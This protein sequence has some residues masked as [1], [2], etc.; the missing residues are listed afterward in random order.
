M[1]CRGRYLCPFAGVER[2]EHFLI[3]KLQQLHPETCSDDKT[4]ATSDPQ[5]H[6]QVEDD[7]FLNLSPEDLT[8]REVDAAAVV[9]GLHTLVSKVKCLHEPQNRSYHLTTLIPERP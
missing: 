9:A 6:H 4:A 3:A 1:E 5:E 8:A 2:C 7:A